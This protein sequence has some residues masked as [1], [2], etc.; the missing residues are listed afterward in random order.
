LHI[1]QTTRIIFIYTLAAITAGTFTTVQAILQVLIE[2]TAAAFFVFA[3]CYHVNVF[4]VATWYLIASPSLEIKLGRSKS[5]RSSRVGTSL[6]S[7]GALDSSAAGQPTL[8]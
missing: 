2:N 5:L 4:V 1:S 8:E 7:K 6:D 3:T